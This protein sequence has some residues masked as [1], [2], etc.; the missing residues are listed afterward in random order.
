MSNPEWLS[1]KYKRNVAQLAQWT[2]GT[3][4][5]FYGTAKSATVSPLIL[6]GLTDR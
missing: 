2:A 6:K 5:Y 3:P 4:T 1:L